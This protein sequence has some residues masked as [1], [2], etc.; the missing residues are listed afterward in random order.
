MAKDQKPTPKPS[1]QRKKLTKNKTT[2]HHDS[3][4]IKTKPLREQ[5]ITYTKTQS[6]PADRPPNPMR[7]PQP[8]HKPR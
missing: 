3:N 5:N 7:K 6:L 4:A 2:K 8:P 1:Q